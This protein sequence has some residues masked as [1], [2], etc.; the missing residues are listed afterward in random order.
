M[1][2]NPDAQPDDADILH[3][4]LAAGAG[5]AAS[6]GKWSPDSGETV[7]DRLGVIVGSAM[8]YEPED[9]PWEVPLIELG[10]DSLMA[11]RIKNRVEYDFDMPPIQLTAVRDASLNDVKALI[12]YA[13]ETAKET[14]HFM[15]DSDEFS[16]VLEGQMLFFYQGQTYLLSEGDCVFFDGSRPH[17]GQAYGGK[18]CRTLLILTPKG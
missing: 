14:P 1:G 4:N 3:D 11:V 17:G 7:H 13:V 8:G 6:L 2:Q 15:H 10:L 16:F 9:L 5:V 12:T 18:P